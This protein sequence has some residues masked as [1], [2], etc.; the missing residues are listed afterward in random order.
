MTPCDP[1]IFLTFEECYKPGPRMG[2]AVHLS[3]FLR[4]EAE[5]NL[6]PFDK[7]P[8]SSLSRII[9][10]ILVLLLR[11]WS[12]RDFSPLKDHLSQLVGYS[13]PKSPEEKVLEVEEKWR[14]G[15]RKE[16]SLQIFEI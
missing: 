4:A 11:A 7:S 2:R 9:L 15:I 3:G 1:D 13:G 8:L 16:V 6:S 14:E 12:V 10:N 5:N